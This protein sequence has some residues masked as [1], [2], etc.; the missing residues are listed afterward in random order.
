M[1][2]PVLG[3]PRT[4]GQKHPVNMKLFREVIDTPINRCDRTGAQREVTKFASKACVSP[5]THRPPCSAIGKSDLLKSQAMLESHIFRENS[6][7]FLDLC[8]LC[9][10]FMNLSVSFM[11]TL[12]VRGLPGSVLVLYMFLFSHS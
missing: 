4:W 9:V 2:D 8:P 6:L 7:R 11:T 12:E 5:E 3:S 10:M 1:C